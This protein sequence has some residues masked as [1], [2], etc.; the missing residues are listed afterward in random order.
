MEVKKIV[1]LHCVL[2]QMHELD[3][4]RQ[5]IF[6]F[7]VFENFHRNKELRLLEDSLL[8]RMYDK[9]GKSYQYVSIIY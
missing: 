9:K 1:F 2:L 4:T 6:E 8:S 5:E 3:L 7:G